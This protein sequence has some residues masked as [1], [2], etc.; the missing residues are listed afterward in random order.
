MSVVELNFVLLWELGEPVVVA[1]LVPSDD[2]VERCR[3]EEVLLLESELLS[4][5]SAV[6]GVENAGNVLS[7]LPV[8][9]GSMEVTRVKFIEI[10]GVVGP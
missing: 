2:I 6:V 1:L 4:G 8:R 9:N 5:V 10:E 7:I 3:A